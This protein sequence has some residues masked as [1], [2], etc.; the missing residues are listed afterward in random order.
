MRRSWTPEEDNYIRDNFARLSDQQIADKLGRSLRSI[1]H[2]RK[3][4]GNV[5]QPLSRWTAKE[6][7]LIRE[8]IER[9][10]AA[11]PLAARLGRRLCEVS[12]RARYLGLSFRKAKGRKETYRG[13]RVSGHKAGKRVFEHVEVMESSIGRR[14]SRHESVH[15]INCNKLDNSLDNLY[16]CKDEGEHRSIHHS[17]NALAETLMQRGVV[18]FNKESAQYELARA[19]KE[20]AQTESDVL[21]ARVIWK[22]SAEVIHACEAETTSRRNFRPNAIDAARCSGGNCKA[23]SHDSLATMNR[24]T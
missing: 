16:L 21:K 13:Y 4:L 9:G 20:V 18:T 11:T 10:E 23:T 24:M 3:R 22:D 8:T 2:R 7:Q 12:S 17:L 5:K 14:L 1:Q 19:A 15:H 6:D